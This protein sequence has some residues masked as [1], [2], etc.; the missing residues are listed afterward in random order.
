MSRRNSVRK[1]TFT[2]ETVTANAWNTLS[3]GGLGLSGRVTRVVTR[4]KAGGTGV[5][6]AK[7]RL[8]NGTYPDILTTPANA[9]T[10]P[11]NDVALEITT[12]TLAPHATTA[13]DDTNVQLAQNGATYSALQDAESLTIALFVPTGGA[14]DVV[15]TVYAEEQN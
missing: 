5:A 9:G 14:G 1:K 4:M 8:I 3:A 13:N 10:A 12:I 2:F 11:D 7:V 15:V 6:A